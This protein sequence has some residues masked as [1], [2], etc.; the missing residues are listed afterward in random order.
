MERYRII[1]LFLYIGLHTTISIAQSDETPAYRYKIDYNIPES[2]AFAVLDANPTTVLRASTPQEVIAHLASDFLSGN[3]ISPGLA[4]DFNPYFTFGGRLESISDYRK[5][6]WKRVLAN[7]QV[8]AATI[9]SQAFPDDLLFSGGIRAVLFDAKDM[10]YDT[11]LAEDIDEALLPSEDQEPTPFQDNEQGT[12][13][14]N[15][16]LVTAYNNAKARYRKTAGGSLAIGYAIAGRAKNNS[17]QTDSIV[18]YRHQAWLAGQYDLGRSQ[19]SLNGMLMYRYDQI[20]ENTDE[21]GWISGLSLRRY[22]EKLILSAEL[23]H[24]SIS[25][26]INFG[27]YAEAYLLPNITVFVA[28]KNETNPITGAEETLIKP[29][30]KWNLSQTK[31]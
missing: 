20:I 23:Y 30:I 25:E 4:L 31:K 28:I 10:L 24:D 8:S 29:G 26:S 2:P 6:Y 11:Q 13:V 12:I 1:L 17:F 9:N 15:T 21:N 7:L 18:T 22:G 19:L 27:G 14:E 16:K 5:N 3:D